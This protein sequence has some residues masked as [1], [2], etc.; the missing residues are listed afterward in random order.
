MCAYSH[1]FQLGHN[2]LCILIVERIDGLLNRVLDVKKGVAG[3]FEIFIRVL[4]Q[5]CELLTILRIG[6]AELTL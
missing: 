2:L 5:C 1:L 3:I 6:P 4:A